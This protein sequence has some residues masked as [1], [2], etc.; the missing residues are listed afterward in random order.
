MLQTEA[1]ARLQILLNETSDGFWTSTQ[2]YKLLDSAQSTKIQ[3]LLVLMKE[4]RKLNPYYIPPE[5][6]V[7]ITLDTTNTTTVGSA[8]QEYSV[9]A[10]FLETYRASYDYTGASPYTLYEATLMSYEDIK[11][12][13]A[14]TYEAPT[15]TRPAYYYKAGKIGFFPQPIGAHANSFEH[16]YIK[17]PS[18]VASGQAFTLLANTHEEILQIAYQLAKVKDSN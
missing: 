13:N 2:L 11:K 5:L 8:E 14:N 9:P 6:E 10:D 4:G 12:R 3:Q 1:L 17:Q 16:Y 15:A 7:L 18:A